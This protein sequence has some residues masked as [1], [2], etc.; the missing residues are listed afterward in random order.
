MIYNSSSSSIFSPFRATTNEDEED[1]TPAVSRQ[2]LR[3]SGV[4]HTFGYSAPTELWFL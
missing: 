2:T 3:R 4:V 1:Q